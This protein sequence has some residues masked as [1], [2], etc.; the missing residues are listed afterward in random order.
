MSKTKNITERFCET[1][2]V[3]QGEQR[4]FVAGPMPGLNE[5][6]AYRGRGWQ[7][8]GKVWDHYND[9]KKKWA[10]KIGAAC[11]RQNVQPCGASYFTFFID[12]PNNRRDPDNFC[13]GAIKFIFDALVE[14]KLLAS[15][16]W[17][18][19]LGYVCYWGVNDLPGVSVY[20][21]PDRLLT[22]EE[23]NHGQREVD[24]G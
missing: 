8:K 5:L 2:P 18:S 14:N 15:D 21:R 6:L 12:E 9:E 23:C 16:G 4:L 1:T 19:I 17:S 24:L 20:I 3:S 22:K 7:R 13:G 11:K 10:E